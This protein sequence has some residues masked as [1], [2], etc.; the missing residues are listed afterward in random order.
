MAG[1][2]RAGGLASGLDTNSI[3]EQLVKLEGN[4]VTAAQKRQA[5]FQSQVSQLGD[6]VS[7]LKALGTSAESLKSSGALGLSQVGTTTGFSATPTSTANAGRYAVQINELATAAKAKTNPLTFASATDAVRGGSISISING[8]VSTIPIAD[9][10]S[11]GDVAKAINDSGAAATATVLESNGQAVL[12]LTNKNT[13]FTPGQPAASGLTIT[14]STTGVLGQP[15][16]LAVTEDAKNA[17][18]TVDGIQFERSSNSASDILPGVSFVLKAKTTSAEDLVLSTD[19]QAT[20]K[21]LEDFVSKYNAVMSVLRSNLN[22]GEQTDRSQTL[23]G[24]SSVRSLQGSLMSLVSTITNPGSTVRALADI[25]IKTQNDGT[26]AIDQ[27]KLTSAIS[28]DPDAVNA[29]F[30]TATDGVGDKLKTLVDGYTNSTDGIFVSKTK[31][32]NNTVKQI[33]TQIDSLQMRVDAYREKLIAQFTAMEK[34][35]SGFKSIGN[36]LTSQE[37][38]KDS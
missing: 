2:F 8:T 20:A 22:I 3:I 35:V 32:L 26:L 14:A 1:T 38:K 15:L 21:N 17:L 9:G 36:Y 37:A 34:I 16:G 19:A 7:K 13:G 11:L 6:L 25:G 5:A 4:S 27:A 31:S 28:S 18:V 10:M 12:S 24:D 29:L 23:G 33:S 30:Q